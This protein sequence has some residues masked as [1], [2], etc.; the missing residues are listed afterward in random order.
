M[1]PDPY[2][3]PGCYTRTLNVC[4]SE[5]VAA[6]D[7]GEGGWIRGFRNIVHL[8]LSNRDLPF[9]LNPEISYTSFRNISPNLKTLEVSSPFLLRARL[10]DIIYSSP[11]LENLVLVGGDDGHID[12]EPDSE[13][14]GTQVVVSPS[15][16]PVLAGTLDLFL[17][18]GIAGITHRLLKLPS[19]L[20]SRE[21]TLRIFEEE[22]IHPVAGLVMA[23]S[24]TL[25][26][27][28]IAFHLEGTIYTVHISV[29]PVAH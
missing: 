27:L 18:G 16:S 26:R 19:G 21:L 14:D 4:C 12:C 5:V 11:L 1:F 10:F 25:E 29:E 22:D 17:L 23:C 15:N 28:D 20:H 7:A 9:H 8:Y 3:S 2:N 24:E 13:S 6:A